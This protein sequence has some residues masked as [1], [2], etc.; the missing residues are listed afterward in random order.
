M[1]MSLL[2]LFTFVP[3][4]ANRALVKHEHDI[5]TVNTPASC[6]FSWYDYGIRKFR[7]PEK[8]CGLFLILKVSCFKKSTYSEKTA[9]LF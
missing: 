7:S 4:P 3:C 9:Q 8:C 5:N 2:I 6:W 1:N